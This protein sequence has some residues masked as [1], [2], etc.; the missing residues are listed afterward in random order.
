[1]SQEKKRRT[2]QHLLSDLHFLESSTPVCSDL[3]KGGQTQDVCST[4]LNINTY[5][6]CKIPTAKK[7][8]EKGGGSQSERRKIF[9]VF[10]YNS[11]FSPHQKLR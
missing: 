8:A 9:V 2:G 6:K 1:M 7:K 3:L 11:N 4:E 5:S 10:I